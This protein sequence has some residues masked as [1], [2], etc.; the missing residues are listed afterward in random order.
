MFDLSLKNQEIDQQSG[1]NEVRKLST[2]YIQSRYAFKNKKYQQKEGNVYTYK[3][4]ESKELKTTKTLKPNSA[5]QKGVICRGCGKIYT[6]Y[7]IILR[8]KHLEIRNGI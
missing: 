8:I 4:K 5:I 7:V 2:Q 3:K 6:K 1:K